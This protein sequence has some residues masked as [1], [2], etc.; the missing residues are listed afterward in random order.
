MHKSALLS[1]CPRKLYKHCG[2]RAAKPVFFFVLV[3]VLVLFYAGLPFILNKLL[4]LTFCYLCPYKHTYIHTRKEHV[5]G[6]VQ[7][8]QHKWGVAVPFVRERRH[9]VLLSLLQRAERCVKRLLLHFGVSIAVVR[10]ISFGVLLFARFSFPPP[11][12]LGFVNSL[13]HAICVVVKIKTR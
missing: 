10:C 12:I 13:Q 3:L 4:L 5:C 9:S 6:P 7:Q 8:Q 11:P 1:H 2:R